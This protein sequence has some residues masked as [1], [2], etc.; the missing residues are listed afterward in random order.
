MKTFAGATEEEVEGHKD[1]MVPDPV[2]Q[3]MQPF[4]MKHVTTTWNESLC[5]QFM[6]HYQ[7]Q[8]GVQFTE[9][10]KY[11]V[12]IMF[13]ERV[14]QMSHVWWASQKERGKREAEEVL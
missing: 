11:E 5:D 13:D 4:L 10:Q 7:S 6:E 9:E 8:L 2:L 3:P 14:E 1:G 12:A